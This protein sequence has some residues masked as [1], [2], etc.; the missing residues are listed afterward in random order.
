M[1]SKVGHLS[2]AQKKDL[3]FYLRNIP[4]FDRPEHARTI[5]FVLERFGFEDKVCILAGSVDFYE[6]EK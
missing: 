3:L 4:T 1:R 5:N 6:K 2:K